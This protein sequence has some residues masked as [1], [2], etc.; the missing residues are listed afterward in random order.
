MLGEPIPTKMREQM[1]ADPY[2]HECA[3]ANAL[4]DHVCQG[5]PMRGGRLIEW[6]HAMYYAGSKINEPWAIVP[7]CWLVHRGGEMIKEVNQWLALNRATDED[8][9]KYP[10]ADFKRQ[11]EYLNGKY[12]VPPMAGLSTKAPF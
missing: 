4:H 2:Y 6:E 7:I 8:L 5:D 11:R 12:G 3:R 10:K 9:A 1:D